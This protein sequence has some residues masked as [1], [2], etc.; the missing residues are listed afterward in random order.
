MTIINGLMK[1]PNTTPV[2]APGFQTSQR[3]LGVGMMLGAALAF[4]LLS[5]F[6]KP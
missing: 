3:Y 1:D 5:G 2:P 6:I 4:A